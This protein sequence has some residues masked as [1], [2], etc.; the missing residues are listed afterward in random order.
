MTLCGDYTVAKG[1]GDGW[2]KLGFH[3][4]VPPLRA[5][6]N[7]PFDHPG[8]S[9][10]HFGFLCFSPLP[11]GKLVGGRIYVR[12]TLFSLRVMPRILY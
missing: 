12:F 11:E 10:S 4:F 8:T 6:M 7:I 9:V 3:S 1:L 2:E 5:K